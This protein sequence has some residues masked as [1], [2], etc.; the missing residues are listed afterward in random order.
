MVE[1]TGTEMAELMLSLVETEMGSDANEASH[2]SSIGVD[3]TVV[4]DSNVSWLSCTAASLTNS[5]EE[6]GEVELPNVGAAISRRTSGPGATRRFRRIR[7][8][9]STAMARVRTAEATRATQAKQQDAYNHL[10]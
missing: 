8:V 10:L 1:A 9:H 6:G 2:S 5:H 7:T 4:S 3:E